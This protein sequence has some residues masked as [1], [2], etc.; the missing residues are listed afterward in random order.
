M[1]NK[2]M[3]FEVEKVLRINRVLIFFGIHV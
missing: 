1:E 2:E 3:S